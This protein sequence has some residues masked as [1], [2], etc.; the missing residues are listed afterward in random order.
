MRKKRRSKWRRLQGRSLDERKKI[1][2]KKSKDLFAMIP[3][4]I[5]EIVKREE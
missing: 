3:C 1:K 4:G 5:M 2:I